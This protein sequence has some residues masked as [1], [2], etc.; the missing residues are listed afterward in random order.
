MQ[1]GSLREKS[2]ALP[3]QKKKYVLPFFSSLDSQTHTIIQDSQFDSGNLGI[4][5]FETKDDQRLVVYSAADTNYDGVA[6][7]SRSWF[8]FRIQGFPLG[9]RINIAVRKINALFSL[10]KHSKSYFRP[11]I[12]IGN[13]KWSKLEHPAKMGIGDN[14]EL[15][16]TWNYEFKFDNKKTEIYFAFCYPYD[17]NDQ[18]KDLL[19]WD[20][21]YYLIISLLNDLNLIKYFKIYVIL[22]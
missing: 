21:L 3:P 5:Y 22:K 6:N 13:G 16:A 14:K 2:Q 8:Y 1:A 4:V 20:K 7:N 15:E 9:Q 10:Y 12:K 18:Q 19:S 11:A 17:L